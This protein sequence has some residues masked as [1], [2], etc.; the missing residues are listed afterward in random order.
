MVVCQKSKPVVV[1]NRRRFAFLTSYHKYINGVSL[2]SFQ[3]KSIKT[4]MG[5]IIVLIDE[6]WNLPNKVI[7]KFPN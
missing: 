3:E 2:T 1:D 4:I 6:V 7:F 5:P